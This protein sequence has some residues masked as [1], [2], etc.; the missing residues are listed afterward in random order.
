MV[1]FLPPPGFSPTRGGGWIFFTKISQNRFWVMKLS[2]LGKN[3][4]KNFLTQI[5]VFGSFFQKNFLL[6][7]SF[8]NMY[9]LF[10]EIRKELAWNRFWKHLLSG[11]S[12]I[13]SPETAAHIQQ[14]GQFWTV[15]GQ[16]GQN[17]IFFKKAFGTFFSLLKALINS[18]VSEKSNEGIPRIMRKTSIFGNFGQKWPILDSFWPKWAKRD[19]FSKKRLEHFFRLSEF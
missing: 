12:G 17:G 13:S 6:V 15:F 3:K 14:N 9:G 10:A 2:F 4:G 11:F 7:P 16:N 19:F 1:H 8:Q 5:W 18:K